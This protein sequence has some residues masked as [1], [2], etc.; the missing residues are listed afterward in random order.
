MILKHLF[1]LNEFKLSIG[2]LCGNEVM[3]TIKNPNPSIKMG[4]DLQGFSQ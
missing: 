2:V 4:L 3:V 1:E